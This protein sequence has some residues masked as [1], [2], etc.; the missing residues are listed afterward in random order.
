M[1]LPYKE[2]PRGLKKYMRP[3]VK[4][5]TRP[6]QAHFS[7]MITGLIINNKKTIQEINDALSERDQS[8]L[9]RFLNNHDLAKLNEIRLARVQR[10]LPTK[11]DGLLIIDDFL[12]HKTGKQMEGAGWHRSGVTK[13]KEWG[14]C[15]VDSLYTHPDWKFG[16]PV[17]ADIYT[18]KEN[19]KNP[20]RSKK[21]MALEQISY[22]R[23]QGIQGIACADSLFYA[24]YII[25]ELDDAGEL[26]LLGTTSQ[27]KISVARAPRVSLAEYFQRASF[28]RVRIK[29]RQYLI[30]SVRASIRNVGVRRIICSFPEGHEEDNK[31]FY[32][33]NQE[34]PN[35]MLM[36]LLI[37]RWRIESWHRDAKQHLGI[38]DYQVRKDRAVRNVVLA[39]LIAYT[40]LVLSMLHTTLRHLSER[41]GRQLQTIGE[42]CRFMRLA[43][44]KGWRWITRTLRDHLEVLKEVLNREVLVKNAKV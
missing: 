21:Q 18:K 12:A 39:V 33:T 1:S 32:V 16:Y 36:R 14:H 42:L 41:I 15:I 40:I 35:K 34:C 27:L 37:C 28:E 11:S 9:N 10:A 31:K 5:L 43:A 17:T 20:Y 23:Q 8:N 6:Q 4:E 2:I 19:K 24:D 13:K 22:A 25:H 29:G 3:Y 30:S 26:Y 44:R 38:E 7:T